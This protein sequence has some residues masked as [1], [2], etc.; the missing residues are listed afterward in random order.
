MPKLFGSGIM[1]NKR[2]N[3]G[4]LRGTSPYTGEAFIRTFKKWR[5]FDRHFLFWEELLVH[6]AVGS[7]SAVILAFLVH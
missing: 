5:S 2:T 6:G 7:A 4:P 1:H 3:T